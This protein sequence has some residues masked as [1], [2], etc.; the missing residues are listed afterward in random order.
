MPKSGLYTCELCGRQFICR[1]TK[2]SHKQR[3]HPSGTI[4][5]TDILNR[6][7][8]LRKRIRDMHTELASLQNKYMIIN[9]LQDID[10]DLDATFDHPQE[11]A[12]VSPD[13][14]VNNRVSVEQLIRHWTQM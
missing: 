3:M 7:A 9:N 8:V 10:N 4:D 6:M 2:F 14:D 13:I 1:Q 11:H 12:P 5:N